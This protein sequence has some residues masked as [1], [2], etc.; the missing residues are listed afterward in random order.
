MWAE[1]SEGV[2]RHD[3]MTVIQA[4]WAQL[5]V[6]PGSRTCTSEAEDKR[7]RN[8]AGIYEPPAL[9]AW[10][11]LNSLKY[12]PC[13]QIARNREGGCGGS[14]VRNSVWY[15]EPSALTA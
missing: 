7:V 9:T 11:Q 1:A 14:E 10:T 12:P 15:F 13:F 8:S 2:A 6:A 3:V 4:T 5:H